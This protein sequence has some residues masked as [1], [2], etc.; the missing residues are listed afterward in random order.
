M[1]L[2]HHTPPDRD[3]TGRWKLKDKFTPSA[4]IE[5]DGCGAYYPPLQEVRIAALD[6][7]YAGMWLLSLTLEGAKLI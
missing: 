6:E 2:D 1:K 5:C 4:R 3:C 7:N